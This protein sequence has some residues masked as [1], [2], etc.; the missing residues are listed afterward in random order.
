MVRNVQL[1][2]S[3]PSLTACVGL[4]TH[5][6]CRP[7]FEVYGASVGT[8]EQSRVNVCKNMSR[9]SERQFDSHLF[10]QVLPGRVHTSFSTVSGYVTGNHQGEHKRP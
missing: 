9:I 4:S 8:G 3:V 2:V 7:C 5:S 10:Y 1:S 6:L